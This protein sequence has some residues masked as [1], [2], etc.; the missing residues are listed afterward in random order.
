MEKKTLEEVLKAHLGKIRKVIL[1]TDNGKAKEDIEKWCQRD[2]VC[3]EYDRS[4]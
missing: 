2:F 4:A 1:K 3:Y